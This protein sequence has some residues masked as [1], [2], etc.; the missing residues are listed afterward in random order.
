MG[1]RVTPTQI[2]ILLDGVVIG[3]YNGVHCTVFSQ[4]AAA[5][6]NAPAISPSTGVGFNTVTAGTTFSNF[7]FTPYK[8]S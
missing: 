4:G 6:G 3:T 1:L 2:D 8:A 7:T 5:N